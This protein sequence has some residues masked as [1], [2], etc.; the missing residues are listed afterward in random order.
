M[1]LHIMKIRFTLFLLYTAALN[2]TA[3]T[4][5]NSDSLEKEITLHFKIHPPEAERYSDLTKFGE[6]NVSFD[7]EQI[8]KELQLAEAVKKS[9]LID[10]PTMDV[11]DLCHNI[12]IH[13]PEKGKELLTLLNQ[14]L[15]DPQLIVPFFMQ[16]VFTG[17]FGEQLMLKNLNS[18]NME[19][20]KECAGYLA[21]FAAYESSVPLIQKKIKTTEDLEIQ[22]DLIGALTFISSKKSIPI[23]RKMIETTKD[24]ETQSKAIFA[25]TELVGYEGLS[26]LEKIKTIGEKSAH[27][28][29]ISIDWIKK[30]TNAQNK[31][32]MHVENDANFISRFANVDSPAMIWLKKEGLLDTSKVLHPEP[33][34]I[35]KKR[36]LLTLLIESKGIGLEAA[37]GQLFLSLQQ[38]DIL[39]LLELRKSC[40]YSPNTFSFGRL[41]TVGVFVRYL[42][43]TKK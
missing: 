16:I 15:K 41:S 39:T 27:E 43:K 37:K 25:Y 21:S 33:L 7:K 1:Y 19:W 10:Y 2:V 40:V 14:P 24:D 20:Q 36:E 29:K 3:Q 26:Y 35:D 4:K 6:A 30:E 34:A 9:K 38:T 28:Q 13:S 5:I 22:Q 18:P 11:L 23:I 12:S 31:Y 8:S 32:A 42:R 17:E